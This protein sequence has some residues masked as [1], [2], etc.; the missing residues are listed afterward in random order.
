MCGFSCSV[1]DTHPQPS[2]SQVENGISRINVVIPVHR[3]AAHLGRSVGS[4]A[5]QRFD[6]QLNVVIAINDDLPE[7]TT[8]ACQRA[9]ELVRAGAR[10][11]TLRTSPGRVA[12]LREADRWLPD[13]GPRLYLDEDAVLSPDALAALAAVLAPG[14]GVHFAVPELR[15]AHR[16][17]VSR[18]YFRVWRSLPYV[19]DSPVTCGAYAVSAEGRRRWREVPT[20][21]SDDKWVRWQF[22]PH[23]RRVLSNVSYEVL[24][25]DG[26]AELVR[27]R[28]R[29]LR[30]NRELAALTP[31]A[32]YADDHR[33]YAGV[34][35]AMV[36]DAA[37]WPA[38][39][40]FLL[41][42]LLVAIVAGWHRL[43]T[44][45]SDRPTST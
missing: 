43:W 17:R 21:H 31:R 45:R 6:G 22:A 33:R 26:L 36:A 13:D 4:L 42:H 11:A 34:I 39:L 41:V 23:E 3:G 35:R 44:I 7:T 10:C 2:E 24:A 29:Y 5:R 19:R 16:T 12:A 25:P 32:A 28:C 8:A 1:R 30:G 20:L 40:V 15:L 14:S 9:A 18:A 38:V 37:R 27:A